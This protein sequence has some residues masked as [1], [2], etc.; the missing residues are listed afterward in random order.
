MEWI[1]YWKIHLK[2]FLLLHKKLYVFKYLKDYFSKL[3]AGFVPCYSTIKINYTLHVF[4]YSKSAQRSVN[5]S[6]CGF[7]NSADV[8]KSVTTFVAIFNLFFSSGRV[9]FATLKCVLHITIRRRKRLITQVG[10]GSNR[11]YWLQCPET[12]QQ[13]LD[14]SITCRN[15]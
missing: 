15:N 7:L 8:N 13:P 1:Q 10:W 3:S 12:R 2:S 4:N 14:T 5:I 6:W 9:Q 11:M